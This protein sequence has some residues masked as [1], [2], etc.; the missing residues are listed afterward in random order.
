VSRRKTLAEL[1]N[2]L[3]VQQGV[4]EKEVAKRAP[5]SPLK[6]KERVKSL[7]DLSRV[8]KA[9]EGQCFYNANKTQKESGLQE[10]ELK[11]ETFET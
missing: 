9:Q 6:E 1:L 7:R 5:N 4:L 2:T 3:F 11:V 10:E 8:D